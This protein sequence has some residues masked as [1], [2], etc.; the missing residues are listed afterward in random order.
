MTD[1]SAYWFYGPL[2]RVAFPPD[3]PVVAMVTL[4]NASCLHFSRN[5]DVR[6]R[7][8]SRVCANRCRLPQCC[9]SQY[10]LRDVFR[11]QDRLLFSD[12][13]ACSL[14]TVL[15]RCS[16][17]TNDDPIMNQ[18]PYHQTRSAFTRAE[19][20]SQLA[21]NG[22][23][24]DRKAAVII[25]TI[26]RYALQTRGERVSR[27]LGEKHGVSAQAR[28]GLTAFLAELVLPDPNHLD[29]LP[30]WTIPHH[31]LAV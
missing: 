22:L 6:E 20:E 23:Y 13:S 29:L 24:W 14:H 9:A 15:T 21:A 25:C 12:Q 11:E 1:P 10:A 7:A 16:E 8:R 2:E 18:S 30:D 26:C 3:S 28:A 27:H 5:V 19:G 17:V 4:W 31:H